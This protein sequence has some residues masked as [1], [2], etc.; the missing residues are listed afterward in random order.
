M[1]QELIHF[2]FSDLAPVLVW[3]E[4]NTNVQKRKHFFC[5]EQE[6]HTSKF[7]TKSTIFSYTYRTKLTLVLEE[8][9]RG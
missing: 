2:T 9:L 8:L 1:L 5:V 3:G 6:L 7:L 4:I